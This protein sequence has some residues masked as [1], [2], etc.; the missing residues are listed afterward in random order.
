MDLTFVVGAGRCG[1]TLLSRMLQAHPEV[2][3]ISELF[4]S[5]PAQ[6]LLAGDLDGQEFW[7]LLADPDPGL[8]AMTLSGINPSEFIYPY[9]T[10]RFNAR[11]GV[12]A[13]CNMVLP[14]L[15]DDPDALYDELAAEVPAWP[16]RP[17]ADQYRALFG[18][19]AIRGGRAT[20]VERS[21]ASLALLPHLRAAFPEARF[22]YLFRDGVDSALSMSKHVGFRLMLLAREAARIAGVRTPSEISSQQ[23]QL[24]P[25]RLRRTLT[26]PFDPGLVMGQALSL[27][28]FGAMW[29][30]MTCQGV[31]ELSK[32]PP[33]CWTT[34]RYEDLV[35]DPAA[36]LTRLARFLGTTAD[37]AWFDRAAGGVDA[38][39]TSASSRLAPRMLTTLRRA[40][41][42]GTRANRSLHEGQPHGRFQPEG[43]LGERAGAGR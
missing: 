8:D 40:C 41:V 1:S 26:P 7:A 21:G 36:E 10:G 16:V 29:S 18:W 25:T 32:L 19:L 3:S 23:S 4:S 35:R 37:R 24:I 28:A 30:E 2:L 39:R 5:V 15:S 6:S 17:I 33:N 12:P 9:A 42:D 27:T 31:D 34:L 38:S 20:V 43:L 14:M 22:V 11:D 13:I